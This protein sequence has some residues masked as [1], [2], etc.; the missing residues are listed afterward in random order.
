[1]KGRFMLSKYGSG[2][3]KELTHRPIERWLRKIFRW[4]SR[5]TYVGSRIDRRGF[6]RLKLED[7][8]SLDLCLT[9]E[10]ERVFC[11]TL[12][13]LSA[14]GFSC[15][16][17]GLKSINGRQNITALFALPLEDTHIIKLE[18]FLVSF[19]KGDDENG[20]IFRF[21]FCEGIKDEDRD[22]IH[23]Y[24]VQKQFETLENLNPRN[25]AE[26]EDDKVLTGD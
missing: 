18:V 3:N 6:Y 8:D 13:N 14:S 19:K 11:T 23:R 1:M 17:E 24:V 2:T 21:R 9:M 26:F 20:D 22:L 5:E 25:D 10:D 12:K 4:K 7:Q 15:Q 16:I